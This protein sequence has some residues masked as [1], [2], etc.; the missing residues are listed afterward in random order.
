MD[1]TAPR[2]VGLLNERWRLR[3][4]EGKCADQGGIRQAVAGALAVLCFLFLL[5]VPVGAN[6]PELNE[7]GPLQRLGVHTR[8]GGHCV[9]S[10]P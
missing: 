8:H 10:F 1:S 6:W 2:Y 9:D 5:P 3:M 4:A 7:Q